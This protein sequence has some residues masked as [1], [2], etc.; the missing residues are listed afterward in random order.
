MSLN[1]NNKLLAP[2]IWESIARGLNGTYETEKQEGNAKVKKRRREIEQEYKSGKQ[3]YTLSHHVEHDKELNRL[4][5]EHKD[6]KSTYYGTLLNLRHANRRFATHLDRDM[7]IQSV[8][9]FE[10]PYFPEDGNWVKDFGGTWDK[11][12]FHRANLIKRHIVPRVSQ[13]LGP[14]VLSH[15]QV[16][17]GDHHVPLFFRQRFPT[18]APQVTDERDFNNRAEFDALADRQAKRRRTILPIE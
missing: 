10:R 14:A 8:K 11:P 1:D 17:V 18:D 15:R 12:E 3:D 7:D 5:T 4:F 6:A 13:R 2:E 9:D 16:R